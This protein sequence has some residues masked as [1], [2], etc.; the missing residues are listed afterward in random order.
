MGPQDFNV[1]IDPTDKQDRE[2]YNNQGIDPEIMYSNY[3]TDHL[4]DLE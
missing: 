4:V 3:S 2:M 1:I